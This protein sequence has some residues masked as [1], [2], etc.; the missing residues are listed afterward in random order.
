MIHKGN[1]INGNHSV[2]LKQLMRQCITN[3]LWMVIKL[4]KMTVKQLAKITVALMITDLLTYKT[5]S[6]LM[7]KVAT[8]VINL[9]QNRHFNLLIDSPLIK[10]FN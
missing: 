8:I 9:Y 7:N 6:Y 10:R 4:T 3:I 5:V 1:K 2:N